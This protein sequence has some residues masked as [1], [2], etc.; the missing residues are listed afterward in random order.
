MNTTDD[1]NVGIPDDDTLERPIRWVR[2]TVV[3]VVLLLIGAL[4]TG[5][6]LRKTVAER[7]MAGWCAERQLSCEGKFVQIGSDGA[8]I[9]DLKVRAGADVPFEASEAS[10]YLSWPRL[11]TPKLTGITVDRPVVRGTLDETGM[12]FYGLE[13]LAGQSDGAGK[14][15]LPAIEITDGRIF[16]ATEAGELSA[17]V[18]MHGTFPKKGTLDLVLD[19]AA[20]KGAESE[21]NWSEGAISLVADMGR[22]S[23]DANIVLERADLNTVSITDAVFTAKIDA[24]DIGDGPMTLNW[25]GSVVEGVIPGGHL[26]AVRTS[27]EAS[28][29]ELPSLSATDALAALTAATFKLESG[30]VLRDGYG[31]STL[32]LE[33]DLKGDAGNIGG[34]VSFSASQAI[35]PQGGAGALSSNGTFSRSAEGTLLYVGRASATDAHVAPD[36]RQELTAPIVFP[37][38]LSDHGSSFR[39]AAVR[40]LSKFDLD[41]AFSAGTRDGVFSFSSR[42]ET[43]LK[44]ASGLRLKIMPPADGPWLS[45]QGPERAVRGSITLSGGGGPDLQFGLDDLQQGTAG[46]QIKAHAFKLKPWTAGGKT[47]SA[48][49]GT[50]AMTSA[51]DQFDLLG[52][53][54]LSLSGQMSGIDL[55]TTEL[56]GGLRATRDE[57]GWQVQ[58][59]GAK[60]VSVS[61]Q[62][63]VFGSI[64]AEPVRLNA[65]PQGDGFIRKGGASPAGTV[66]LGAVN[67]PFSTGSTSGT[68]DLTKASVDWST[69]GG[70]AMTVLA[71][72]LDLPLEIGSRTLILSGEAPRMGIATGSGAPKLSARLG[73]TLFNGKLVPAKVS[74]ESFVF[75]GTSGKG[76]LSGNLNANGVLIQDYRS[77]PLY[78]PLISDMT[79][80]L[81][82][83]QLVMT[84]PLRLKAGGTTVADTTINLDVV[85]LNGTAAIRSRPLAF[86]SGGL[87]PVMLSEKLRGV[88]TLAAGDASAKADVDIVSG[89]LSATGD[90]TIEKFGF[91]TTR[92]GR[93]EDVNGKI[94]FSD[95]LELTT[96][97]GQ[98]VTVG[99]LSIG[100]PLTDGLIQFHLDKGKVLGVEKAGFP[101]A[102]GRIAISPLQWTL[103]GNDQRVEVTAD[104]IELSQLVAVLKL[105]DVQATGTVSGTFPVDFVGSEVQ[106]RDALLAADAKGGR[107]A[108][109][110]DAVNSAA[111]SDPNAKLAFDA[112]KDLQFSVLEI[113]LSGDLMNRTVASVHLIG[114][115]TQPL[116]F[117]KKLTM[118]KGQA[119]EFNLS[120]DSDLAELVKSGSYATQQDKFVKMVVDMANDK[121]NRPDE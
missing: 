20:L 2:W 121:D 17:T 16:F 65:C 84:G 27:G 9:R 80:A 120:L 19:P 115:N 46:L 96:D 85:K 62:G 21:F 66:T 4:A 25:T 70:L 42:Q 13:K 22:I 73:A 40:A 82:N 50:F 24:A 109:T 111:D 95:L 61:S 51:P 43:L 29:T 117:G 98:V 58:P 102:G 45:I 28:F 103:G 59:D 60:C 67:L 116:A 119:F 100:V 74:A 8:T 112:L 48:D 89:K 15:T 37:G 93:I 52:R 26:S 7:A 41:L 55:K 105:P 30:D 83:G 108:Y 18:A 32:S 94:R 33:G 107:I 88:F 57:S 54:R 44:A 5:W 11:F 1:Q 113:G 91:Q 35:A 99:S 64:R 49:L 76:G 75:D 69:N 110:G 118:P 81:T 92:L 63:F 90:V 6:F 106:V 31:A 114:R 3:A 34:P 101:F 12:R 87:Q 78:Q 86:R 39:S 71:N 23:G 72:H 79:A 10:A 97:R 14:V 77:D 47:L 53:G 38:T 68:L 56:V 104:A 36:L